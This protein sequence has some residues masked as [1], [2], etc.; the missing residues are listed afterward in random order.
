MCSDCDIRPA[1]VDF[2]AAASDDNDNDVAHEASLRRS[3]PPQSYVDDVVS[4]MMPLVDEQAEWRRILDEVAD[5]NV[6]ALDVNDDDLH[7]DEEMDDWD[8]DNGGFLS[9]PGKAIVA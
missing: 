5:L 4:P 2:A 1:V 6:G 9:S 3:S 8:P 7:D